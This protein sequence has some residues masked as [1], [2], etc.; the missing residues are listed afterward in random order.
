V[1]L[2]RSPGAEKIALLQRIEDGAACSE[3]LLGA[4]FVRCCVISVEVITRTAVS[5]LLLL[6]LLIA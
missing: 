5:L 3:N 2:G 4:P 6:L 1:D